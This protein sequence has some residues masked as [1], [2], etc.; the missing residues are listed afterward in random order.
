M[1]E[2]SVILLVED[3]ESHAIL[4][5]RGL[6]QYHKKPRIVHVSDGESALDY[7]LGRGE[8][9]RPRSNPR[10][11]LVLL[12]LRL[13]KIDGLDVLKEMK[14]SEDLRVIPVVILTSSMAEPDI[15]RS[16]YYNAN[17]YLVKPLDFEEFRKE[18]LCVANYWLNWNIN[19]L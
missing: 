10:P 11:R 2:E 17:S 1:T 18:M 14:S 12:D 13:P 4:A 9:S 8:Y 3:N 5:I 15:V 16:Y 19:P 7:L 6:S